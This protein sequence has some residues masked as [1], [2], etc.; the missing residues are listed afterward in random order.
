RLSKPNDPIIGEIIFGPDSAIVLVHEIYFETNNERR[1]R[2]ERDVIQ[3]STKLWN[4]LTGELVGKEIINDLYRGK[5]WLLSGDMRGFIPEFGFKG[6]TF[7]TFSNSY[8]QI[9]DSKTG[10]QIGNNI[11]IESRWS[12]I[13]NFNK[14]YI[15]AAVGDNTI[16]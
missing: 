8:F 11:K 6:K 14:K 2:D 15:L 4:I 9:W 3:S 1:S 16:Q 12:P 5:N 7:I 13:Y 10:N